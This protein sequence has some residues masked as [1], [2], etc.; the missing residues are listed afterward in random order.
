MNLTP[1]T[2]HF[3]GN[4]MC[5]VPMNVNNTE[6]QFHYKVY[7]GDGVVRYYD[8]TSL[9]DEIKWKMGMIL[10]FDKKDIN[11]LTDAAVLA[12]PAYVYDNTFPPEFRDIGWQVSP[13]FFCIVTDIETLNDM[14]G[15]TYVYDA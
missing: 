3:D 10:S 7:V 1:I 11:L 8:S 6:I 2:V 4:P 9:P 15:I 13:S 14:K 5:R 12:S